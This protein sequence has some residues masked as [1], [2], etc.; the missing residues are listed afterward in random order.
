MNDYMLV[1]EEVGRHAPKMQQWFQMIYAEG[2]DTPIEKSVNL[3]LFLASGKGDALSGRYIAVNDNLAELVRRA[4]EIQQDDLLTLR[5]R[6]L[7]LL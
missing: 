6:P 4:N 2:K 7:P 1:S 5:L 3:V